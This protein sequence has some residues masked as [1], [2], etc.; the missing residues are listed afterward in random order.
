MFSG[1]NVSSIVCVVNM[2]QEFK[3]GTLSNPTGAD[4]FK[5]DFKVGYPRINL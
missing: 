2:S 4:F 5:K 1:P 3:S